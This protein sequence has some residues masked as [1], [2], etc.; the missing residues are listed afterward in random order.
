VTASLLSAFGSALG[1]F[2]RACVFP[3]FVGLGCLCLAVLI[4]TVR[5]WFLDMSTLDAFGDVPHEMGSQMDVPAYGPEVPEGLGPVPTMVAARVF[6]ES[7]SFVD[8]TSD[9]L[10]A[11]M[12]MSPAQH[13]IRTFVGTSLSCEAGER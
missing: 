13:A 7:Q 6:D 9:R 1:E 3:L 8:E 12:E 2:E 11:G 5:A 4:E 10:P